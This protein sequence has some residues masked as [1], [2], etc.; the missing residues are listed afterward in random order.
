MA[1]KNFFGLL[2][3][4]LTQSFACVYVN[5]YSTKSAAIMTLN[6]LT[7]PPMNHDLDR[8]KIFLK[9]SFRPQISADFSGPTGDA[10]TLIGH[11]TVDTGE[12]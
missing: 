8:W 9:A 5:N 6:M 3:K 7:R 4:Y 2:K 10:W 12:N 1:S 11:W